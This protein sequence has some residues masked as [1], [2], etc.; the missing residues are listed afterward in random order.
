MVSL[1]QYLFH[2]EPLDQFLDRFKTNL[3]REIESCE[4]NYILNVSKE[5]YCNYLISK[6]SLEI[7]VLQENDIYVHEQK[8]LRK[9]EHR[10]PT[11]R[12]GSMLSGIL[13]L[14]ISVPFLGYGQLFKC[15]PSTFTVS[16]PEGTVE[17]SEIRLYYET[18]DR[19]P[20]NIKRSYAQKIKEIKTYLEWVK[21]DVDSHNAWIK[22]NA[23]KYVLKRKDDQLRDRGFL[24]SLGIPLRRRDK[25]PETYSIPTIRK[26]IVV[27]KPAATKE[28]YGPEPTLPEAEYEFILET[29][30][31]MSLAMERSPK[32]FSELQEEEIRDFFII[33]LNSH[34]EGQATGETFNFRGKTDILIRYEDRNAFVAECKIWRGEKSLS[35]TIDQ[36]LRYTNWRDTKTAILLF[37]ENENLTRVLEEIGRVAESHEFYKRKHE[38]KNKKLCNETIFSYIFHQPNDVNRELFLTIMVFDIPAS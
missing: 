34:Y 7:P 8:E 11:V 30:F 23:I 35:S 21:K 12:N 4:P 38:L 15:R 25:I 22:D 36:L 18:S 2:D 31:H 24:E 20:N 37:N 9:E 6:Y 13:A 27:S 5:D 33:I 1:V 28:A 14:T 29:I 10:T 17:E 19:N 16:P 32:T 3:Q 26:K